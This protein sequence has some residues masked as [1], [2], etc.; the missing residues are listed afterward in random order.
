VHAD[1][2]VVAAGA[3]ADKLLA[4]LGVDLE[5]RATRETVVFLR[6]DGITPA[7][8]EE[9]ARPRGELAYALRDPVH[10]LKAGLHRAGE[11]ADPN[12]EGRPDPELVAMTAAWAADRFPSVEAAP[13][14]VET[15]L[16]ANR[17]DDR[18]ALERHGRVVVASACSGHGFK[19]APAVAERIAAL[20]EE[21]L[22]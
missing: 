10:G 19:F 12:E 18:F 21:A 16:Y 5:L 7:F 22:V 20:A 13:V 1:V 4:P 14:A 11:E 15:C 3:W 6:F 8:V 2:A 9:D 17:P